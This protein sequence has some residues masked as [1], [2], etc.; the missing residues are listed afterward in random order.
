MSD[1]FL[2]SSAL[3]T[4]PIPFPLY[5]MLLFK[6]NHLFEFMWLFSL[7]MFIVYS[8]HLS[9]FTNKWDNLLLPGNSEWLMKTI[10][11]KMMLMHLQLFFIHLWYTQ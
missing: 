4:P 11:I 9:G 5:C 7:F 8:T 6:M 3:F 10:I 2:Y 1:T